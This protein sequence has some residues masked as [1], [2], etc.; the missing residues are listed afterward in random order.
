MIFIPL[1]RRPTEE[2][3]GEGADPEEKVLYGYRIG[4]VFDISQTEAVRDEPLEYVSPIPQLQG[5][6]HA[7]LYDDPK[8]VAAELGFSIVEDEQ[9]TV[10]GYC[11]HIRRLIGIHSSQTVHSKTATLAREMAHA[12]AHEDRGETSHAER[13]LQAEGA[14]YMVCF[15]LGLD[16]GG[17]F[18]P[19]LKHYG[20]DEALWKQ[21][22]VI[23]EIAGTLLDAVNRI[24]QAGL[25]EV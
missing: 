12:I 8:A 21:L 2:E 11:S 19:Y 18:L 6:D 25:V 17:G 1:L 3:I 23:E 14:A 7:H 24:R 10:E 22:Q 13:E 9:T 4:Y 16:T 20:D 5:D 15:S